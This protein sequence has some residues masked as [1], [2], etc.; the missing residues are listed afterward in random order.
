MTSRLGHLI[1]LLLSIASLGSCGPAAPPPR[2][3]S[4]PSLGAR[5]PAA[6]PT[7][8]RAER[9]ALRADATVAYEHKA[10][11]RCG[12]LF[13]QAG[14][15][16]NA[17]CCH[18]LGGDRDAA[19]AQL[20]RLIDGKYRDLASLDRDSD[21]ASLHADPRWAA[22]R[23]RLVTRIAEHRAR[24][25]PELLQL[26]DEDQADRAAG[27]Y[28]QIDWSKVAPRDRARRQRVDAIVAAGGAKVADDFFHA[29]MVYQH[30]DRPEEIQRAHDL[31][32]QA[33]ALDPTHDRARWLAAAAEDRRLMYDGKPQKWGTQLKKLDGVWVVWQ[34]DPTI[35]D[36]MREAWNVPPLAESQ[37]NAARMNARL[38]QP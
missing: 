30:G 35:T 19:F 7:P 15:H 1:V 26:H 33:V 37:A 11:A 27:S 9:A 28:E 16:Y 17:A 14:D 31:A 13:E 24:V 38:P 36:A 2:A 6:S 32:L 5:A 3:A 20:A 34:V 18:A 22:E 4:G 10:F 25:H 8:S 12:A 29:A 21:L 23:A